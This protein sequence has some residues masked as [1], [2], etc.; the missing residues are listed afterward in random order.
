MGIR[1]SK[2]ALL[3]ITVSEN[4]SKRVQ[5]LWPFRL[6]VC[7]LINVRYQNQYAN[8]WEPFEPF[9]LSLET[10]YKKS[11]NLGALYVKYYV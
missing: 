2:E 11:L 9:A 10:P 1:D 3:V 6:L 5:P 4:K 7:P 8:K